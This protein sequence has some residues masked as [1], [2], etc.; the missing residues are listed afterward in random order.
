[1][2]VYTGRYNATFKG[3]EVAVNLKD[4]AVA[5]GQQGG[6]RV[7]FV[8]KDASVCTRLVFIEFMLRIHVPWNCALGIGA[9]VSQDKKVVAVIGGVPLPPRSSQISELIVTETGN[10]NHSVGLLQ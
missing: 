10:R 2:C 6:R 1:M 4:V 9:T 3:T 8:V 7:V 5:L